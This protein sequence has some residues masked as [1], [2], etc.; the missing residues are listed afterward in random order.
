MNFSKVNG[1]V[2][3]GLFVFFT[4]I[5]SGGKKGAQ[6]ET[7]R[8]INIRDERWSTGARA[9]LLQMARTL[10]EDLAKT[11]KGQD[12]VIKSLQHALAE[13][14]HSFGTRKKDPVAR[15][16]IG[17]TGTGKTDSIDLFCETFKK[18]GGRVIRFN[19]ESWAWI[20][21]RPRIE[22]YS[23]I[24]N[25]GGLIGPP[26]VVVIDEVDKVA[27][28][29]S[30]G[31]ESTNDVAGFMNEIFTDGKF[32]YNGTYDVPVSNFLF[33]TTMNISPEDYRDFAIEILGGEKSFYDFTVEDFKKFNAWAVKDPVTA[34][35]KLMSRRFR[36][37]TVGRRATNAIVTKALEASDYEQIIRTKLDLA[38]SESTTG[39]NIGRRLDFK[40]DDSFL[41]FLKEKA[42]FAPSGARDSVIKVRALFSALMDYAI[43]AVPLGAGP[44][45][46]SLTQPRSIEIKSTKDDAVTLTIT[47]FAASRPKGNLKPTTPFS[48]EITYNPALRQFDDPPGL[49]NSIPTLKEAPMTQRDRSQS[50][51][52]IRKTRFGSNPEKFTGLADFIDAFLF[53]HRSTSAVI[54]GELNKFWTRQIDPD[55]PDFLVLA[56]LTGTGKSK[57][58]QLIAEKTGIP[59][60][61]TNMQAYTAN[62]PDT[63]PNLVRELRDKFEK[64]RALSRSRGLEG[65]IIW[66]A[67]ELDKVYEIDPLTRQLVERPVMNTVKDLLNHGKAS[68]QMTGGALETIDISLGG[69]FTFV[70]MNFT[71][72]RFGFYG[73]PRITTVE[74]VQLATRR[75]A[76][77]P[78]DLKLLLDS[79]FNPETV[80][81]L[82]DRVLILEAPSRAV[83]RRVIE[84]N[85]TAAIVNRFG[86]PKENT[87]QLQFRLSPAY[88]KHL[89]SEGVIPAFGARYTVDAVRRMVGRDLQEALLKLPRDRN[90]SAAPLEI[91]FDFKPSLGKIVLSARKTGA[92]D[93]PFIVS[94][95]EIS[96]RFP[97]LECRGRLTETRLLAALHEFGHAL[98]RVRTGGRFKSISSVGF[99]NGIGGMVKNN[100][101]E[102]EFGSGT[103]RISELAFFMG[104][105]ALERVL[106]EKQDR[107]ADSSIAAISNGSSGDVKASTKLLW[108]I[109]FEEGFSTIVG[110]LDRWGLL[111]NQKY[112]DFASIPH[113][114]VSTLG[115]ILGDVEEYLIDDLKRAHPVEWYKEKIH[116]LAQKGL[117]TEKEF[118]E[119]I[120]YPYPGEE[121]LQF[122]APS[123]ISKLFGPKVKPPPASLRKA[124]RFK[125][126]GSKITA[127]ENLDQLVYAFYE[128]VKRHFAAAGECPAVIAAQK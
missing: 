102:A 30:K 41:N 73:D 62:H 86:D 22:L 31:T 104:A 32:T 48:I 122:G 110:P 9:K 128:S 56:G 112:A 53:G 52:S 63:N 78:A 28:I 64:A 95:K 15:H 101:S 47:P 127:G 7:Y 100:G 5:C 71:T 113:T 89:F 43:R 34:A 24:M 90:L 6:S 29:D 67:E 60:V 39:V 119:L 12:H 92:K 36:Q 61:Y 96:L 94:E 91:T 45:E 11:I 40:Y 93:A 59:V 76:E 117:M 1:L 58:I 16:L 17:P 51:T 97:S 27:E 23:A 118:Y 106:L 4:S 116:F 120:G 80:G 69:V 109:L 37:N 114:L 124:R 26:L 103:S 87:A 3:L 107:K 123:S 2:A 10:P 14:G 98:T 72:D 81:R 108:D 8:R 50:K 21:A 88:K 33:I 83:F 66:A 18:N 70:T 20:S 111:N 126:P 49:V 115:K 38:I 55:R 105:R 35:S 84:Q 42:V 68:A 44:N 13:Y 25:S 57:F 74:E 99:V 82:F 121:P 125:H 85:T 75:L 19:A 79:I 54:E 46:R 65:K 77:R